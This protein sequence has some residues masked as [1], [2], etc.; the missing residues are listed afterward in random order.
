MDDLRKLRELVKEEGREHQFSHCG[1]A[2]Y[3]RR[4][5]YHGYWQGF[6]RV[7][8]NH[9]WFG[10]RPNELPDTSSI[11]HGGI[12][13]ADNCIIPFNFNESIGK[14]DRS[15]WWF[16]WNAGHKGDLALSYVRLGGVYRTKEFA[17]EQT[18]KLAE[19]LHSIG[20]QAAIDNSGSIGQ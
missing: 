14:V 18:K 7:S 13:Y 16:G 17:L 20:R 3:I 2:C 12:T 9:P 4:H 19:F 5:V 1:L 10:K 8:F 15:V 6:V 11:V